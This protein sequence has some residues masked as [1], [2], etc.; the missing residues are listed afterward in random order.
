MSIKA[1]ARPRTQSLRL[2]NYVK[3]VAFFNVFCY[4]PNAR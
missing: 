4:N 1:H 2:R 3:S